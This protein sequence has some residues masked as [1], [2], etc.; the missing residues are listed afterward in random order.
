M[1]IELEPAI[2]EALD[3]YVA[4]SGVSRAQAISDALLGYLE[5]RQDYERA[6]AALKRGGPTVT[7]AEVRRDLGL[8]D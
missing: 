5:D 4:A 8:D 3:R 6:A 1:T 7:L 2:E